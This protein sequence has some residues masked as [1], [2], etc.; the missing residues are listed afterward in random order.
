MTDKI[1]WSL[2]DTWGELGREWWETN[3]RACGCSTEQI[4]FAVLRHGGSSATAAARGAGYSGNGVALRQAGYRTARS[5]GV[6]NLLALATAADGAG[7]GAIT[8]AEVDGRL[9]K[10]IRSP[11]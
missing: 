10:M 2:P 11:D 5:T 9:A 4:R 1:D 8:D 6:T 3:G 7:E